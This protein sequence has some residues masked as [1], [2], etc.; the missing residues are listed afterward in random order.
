[1]LFANLTEADQSLEPY[2]PRQQVEGTISI[3]GHGAYGKRLQFVEGLVAAWEKGFREFQPGVTFENRLHGTASAIGSLYTGV[4]DIALLGREIWQPEIDAFTEVRG[5]PPTGIEVMT[6][7]FNV[8]NRGYAIVIFVHKDNPIRGL[9]LAQL[10]AIYGVDRRRGHA[11]VSTWSDLGLGGDWADRPVRLYG[12]PIARGFA[13]FVE[14]RVFLGGRKWKPA[15]REYPDDPNSVS[16]ATDGANRLLADLAQ[17]PH[18]IGYA[19]LVYNHPGVR[20]VAIEETRG[21]GPVFPTEETVAD[22]SYP[23]TRV[24]SVFLDRQPGH[25]ADA[26]LEEF[27]RF[28]LSRQGQEIVSSDG[29][30]YLPLTREIADQQM[31]KLEQAGAEMPLSDKSK[32]RGRTNE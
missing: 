29:H 17:D 2:V 20:A 6:G 11:P 27:L 18:G 28:I 16:T 4:G 22:R 12:L 24:I 13:V 25:R 23:L 21:S 32:N 14:D 7:S 3:W 9:T 30:G 8:R 26:K 10:D 19:G 31:R 1:M 15:L 5:Y